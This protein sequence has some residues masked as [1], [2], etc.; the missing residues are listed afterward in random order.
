M[1]GGLGPGSL[2]HSECADSLSCL[3][4]DVEIKGRTP[5][6]SQFQVASSSLFLGLM[7]ISSMTGT[8]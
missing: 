6:H 1:S 4:L 8:F 3:M 7:V 5:I 2:L